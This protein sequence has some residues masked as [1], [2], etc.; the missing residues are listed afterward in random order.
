MLGAFEVVGQSLFKHI[1]V[2]LLF[3]PSDDVVVEKL[4]RCFIDVAFSCFDDNVSIVFSFLP[5]C[6]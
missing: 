4:K 5:T 1:Y 6:F 2:K 3:L